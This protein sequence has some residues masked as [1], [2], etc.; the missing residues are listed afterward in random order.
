M[1]VN[2]DKRS[3]GQ[4][5]EIDIETLLCHE[6]L[7]MDSPLLKENSS[8]RSNRG[9]GMIESLI[10]KGIEYRDKRSLKSSEFR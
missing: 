4:H 10:T 3:Y 2:F 7:D 9:H 1:S 6:D 8:Q 5:E